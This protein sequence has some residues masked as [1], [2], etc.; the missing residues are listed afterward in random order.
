MPANGLHRYRVRFV[1]AHAGAVVVLGLGALIV[2]KV[3]EPKWPAGRIIYDVFAKG[4]GTPQADAG[5]IFDLEIE[6]TREWMPEDFEGS[7]FLGEASASAGFGR[8]KP[9]VG[10]QVGHFHGKNGL[11]FDFDDFGVSVRG[12]VKKQSKKPKLKIGA[13]ALWGSVERQNARTLDLSKPFPPSAAVAGVLPSAA[14][15][16]FGSS[17]LTAAGR[18][19]L[20]VVC[21]E[22]LA[23]LRDASTRIWLVGHTDRPDTFKRNVD[24]SGMRANNV[25]RALLDIL[26]DALGQKRWDGIPTYHFG[27][28]VAALKMKGEKEKSP[29]DRRVDLFVD[30]RL[31]AT[32]SENPL[33]RNT[34]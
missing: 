11:Q 14:H 3:S 9:K 26:G 10:A 23:V 29:E 16:C 25:K 30:G 6:T 15:F 19:Y 8:I 27:E 33:Q 20:R 22:Q 13:L 24:L 31:V 28:L 7:L 21:A 18:Q 2:E 1:L 32:L 34:R 4:V 5:D 17:V 12:Q